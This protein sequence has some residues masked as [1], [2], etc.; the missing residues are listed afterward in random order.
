ME[1]LEAYAN[2]S[3]SGDSECD[4]SERHSASKRNESPIRDL[5]ESAEAGVLSDLQ[6]GRFVKTF[7]TRSSL[8]EAN[9]CSGFA[10]ESHTKTENI[11]IIWPLNWTDVKGAF[12]KRTI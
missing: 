6:S 3:E 7:P 2:D 1:F 11:I 8:A 9:F 10:V 5:S 4:G 12:P